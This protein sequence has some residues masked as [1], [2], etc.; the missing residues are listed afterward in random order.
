MTVRDP[1]TAPRER[2]SGYKGDAWTVTMP[3]SAPDDAGMTLI[4]DT[5]LDSV[6]IV[7]V[8][9]GWWDRSPRASVVRVHDRYDETILIPRGSGTL[10]HGA[11]PGDITR[12]RFAAPVTLVLP[13]G[14]WHHVAMDPDVRVEATAFFTV[15]GTVIAPFSV[16]M[17]IVTRARIPFG[18]L[19]V[20]HPRPVE[21]QFWLPPAID[22][23]AAAAATRFARSDDAVAV[24]TPL[25]DGAAGRQG[26]APV[27]GILPY[28]PPRDGL[29]MPLDTGRDSLFI[30]AGAPDPDAPE[31]SPVPPNPVLL[32]LPDVVDV[33]RHPDVDEYILRH[34]GAGYILN[35]PTPDTITRTPFRGPCLLVMP[36]GAFHRIVQTEDDQVGGGFLIYADRRAVV[37]PYATIMATT[38][39]ASVSTT[40]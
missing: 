38:R 20:V 3:S 29:T 30:L 16:Q 36:A 26:S 33:H 32:D 13:A 8:A 11:D 34:G 37:E 7:G 24:S 10:Y 9:N 15:P 35:G 39:V 27:A 14:C 18:D 28:P 23:H 21:G 5:G 25:E 19:P 40:D 2:E 4:L 12:S 6:A 17:D 1:A 22:V 31:P